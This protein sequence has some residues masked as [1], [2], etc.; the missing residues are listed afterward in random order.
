ML[1]LL[2]FLYAGINNTEERNTVEQKKERVSRQK[3]TLLCLLLFPL[4]TSPD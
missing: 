2:V 3:P 1:D 4:S